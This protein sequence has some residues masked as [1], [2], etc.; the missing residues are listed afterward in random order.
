MTEKI[1]R[2]I[3]DA[4]DNA[5][6]ETQQAFEHKLFDHLDSLSDSERAELQK[7]EYRKTPDQLTLIDFA[8]DE[9]NRLRA[10][11]GLPKY[12]MP[13][14]NYHILPPE[15]YK[16]ASGKSGVGVASFW[17]QTVLLNADKLNNDLYKF[18]HVVLHESLH[19][20]GHT[21]IEVAERED[22]GKDGKRTMNTKKGLMREGLGVN[23]TIRKDEEGYEHIHFKGL[24]EAVVAMFEKRLVS[25]MLELPVLKKEK[26]RLSSPEVIKFKREIADKYNIDINEINYV[27]LDRREWDDFSYRRH[28][29]VLD[30]LCQEIQSQFPDRFSD[31]DDVLKEFARAHFAGRLIGLAKLIDGTF[32]PGYFRILGNMDTNDN[33]AIL[34][35][36]TFRKAR[37]RFMKG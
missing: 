15:L 21:V 33:S 28:R 18:G 4:G 17:K 14:D 19:L 9:T 29:E 13:Y 22:D 37:I 3:G 27:N 36:E 31:K 26:D 16:K 10:E 5:K 34:T 25:K 2:I 24:H 8:N 23:S 6:A 11:F 32:G 20:K 7:M 1:F 12:D 35:L 30:Y